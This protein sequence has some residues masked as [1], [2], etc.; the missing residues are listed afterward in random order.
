MQNL[1]VGSGPNIRNGDYLGPWRVGTPILGHTMDVRPEWVS[2][3]GQNL[4]MG[5]NFRLKTWGWVII[6][7]HKISGLV[8]ISIIL[9]GNG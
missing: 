1:A 2:F 5:V 3:R 4:Q 7:I 9:P 8:T 6:L